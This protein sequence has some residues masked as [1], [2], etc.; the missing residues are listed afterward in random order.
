MPPGEQRQM[1]EGMVARL[2]AKLNKAPANPE[3]WIMLIR[4]RVNLGQRDKAVQALKDALAANPG[5]AVMLR[6]QAEV[7]GVR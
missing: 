7:L 3:G 4:S 2:E 5:Q 1:A 6:Q